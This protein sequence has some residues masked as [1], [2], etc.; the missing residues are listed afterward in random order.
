[1]ALWCARNFS[2]GMYF[3]YGGLSTNFIKI[4][5]C[6]VFMLHGGTP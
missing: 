6:N 1:M 5:T 4:K 2:A 3:G